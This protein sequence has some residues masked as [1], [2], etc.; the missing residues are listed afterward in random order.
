MGR[1]PV[2]IIGRR[3]SIWSFLPSDIVSPL[4]DKIADHLKHETDEE[5]EDCSFFVIEALYVGRFNVIQSRGLRHDEFTHRYRRQ[6]VRSGFSEVL[7]CSL[8]LFEKKKTQHS[9]DV[10]QQP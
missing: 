5:E 7:Q 9:G 3:P 8:N 1:H 4:S 10:K 6:I 2:A